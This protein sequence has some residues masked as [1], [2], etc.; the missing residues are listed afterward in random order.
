VSL[1]GFKIT[2]HPQ[3][4]GKRG[5]SDTV[6]ERITPCRVFEPLR[7]EFA[8]TLDTAANARNRKTAQGMARDSAETE[9]LRSLRTAKP[10]PK[11]A[12]HG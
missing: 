7:E 10:G 9:G 5:A 6:D 1:V 3:Q 8:F 11:D 4:V 2:N 12:P